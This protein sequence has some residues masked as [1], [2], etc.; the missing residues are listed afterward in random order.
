MDIQLVYMKSILTHVYIKTNVLSIPI[1]TTI[2]IKD[3]NVP[4]KFLTGTTN[5]L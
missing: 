2:D 3:H 1:V 5:D 4:L